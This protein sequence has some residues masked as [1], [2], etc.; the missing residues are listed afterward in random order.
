M[1]AENLKKVRKSRG[2][3]QDE[4]ASKL[5]ITRQS[6]SKWENGRAFPDVLCLKSLCELYGVSIDE[7]VKDNNIF[8]VKKEDIPIDEN[9]E[10]K[11]KDHIREN[12][13]FL[14]IAIVVVSCFIP[15]LGVLVSLFVLVKMLKSQNEYNLVIKLIIFVCLILSIVNS[16]VIINN[17]YLH[18]GEATIS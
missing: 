16:Y 7:M 15:F 3:S 5:N 12:E 9:G 13:V 14:T 2:Y 10:Q 8:E 1:L 4:V 18:V 11:K 6:L 17:I